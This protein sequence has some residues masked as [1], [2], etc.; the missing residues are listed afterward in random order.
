[1]QSTTDKKFIKHLKLYQQTYLG[2][3]CRL[4]TPSIYTKLNRERHKGVAT[5]TNSYPFE[6]MSAFKFPNQYSSIGYPR[7][8]EKI[9]MLIIK[10]S[11]KFI[12]YTYSTK[13]KT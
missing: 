9:T 12:V 5:F 13:L 6:E 8:S 2:A 4:V 11:L 7:V 1:M 10:V 3:S